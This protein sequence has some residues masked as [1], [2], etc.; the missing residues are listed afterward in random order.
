MPVT[1]H[2]V[3]TVSKEDA[4]KLLASVSAIQEMLPFLI[5]L[6]LE[7][8]KSMLKFG[9]K[10]Q[11]FLSKAADLVRQHP[12]IF[13]PAFDREAFLAEIDLL[14]T[15]SPIRHAV[16]TLFGK[17]QDTCYALGSDA[18]ST[19]LH[20]YTYAK[21]ANVMTGALEDAMDDLG[22]RF[23]RRSSTKTVAGSSPSE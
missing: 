13:P 4:D 22:K 8:R 12:E 10:S 9:D 17:L 18:Y 16:E 23:A 20:V 15:L 21:T 7:T 11:P 19:A 2:V 5:D 14:N 3:G 6:N 1:Q